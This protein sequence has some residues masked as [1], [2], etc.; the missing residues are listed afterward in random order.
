[1]ANT[2]V[3][4]SNTD[5][6]A[7]VEPFLAS[8]AKHLLSTSQ[9]F[10]AVLALTESVNNAIVH[11][12][13]RDRTKN[14]YVTIAVEN[15]ELIMSVEDEGN[16]FDRASLPDPTAP[17]NLLKSGGRGIFLIESVCSQ[18][19]FAKTQRGYSII[20]RLQIQ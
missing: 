15:N 20:M 11:A 13:K 19:T 3:F 2:L 16:G 1:M 6:L 9:Y 8:H 5:N 14:V 17:E 4:E 18:V 10:N 7:L 12:N